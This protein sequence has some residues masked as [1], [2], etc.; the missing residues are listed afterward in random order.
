MIHLKRIL[1]YSQL[2]SD[3][4]GYESHS[5]EQNS[6]SNF[7]QHVDVCVCISW[8]SFSMDT[9]TVSYRLPELVSIMS[10]F[11]LSFYWNSIFAGWINA[12]RFILRH[13]HIFALNAFRLMVQAVCVF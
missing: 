12:L 7:F 10:W 13:T 2:L 3:L 6:L 11:L 1:L 8:N 5:S 9:T 4:G